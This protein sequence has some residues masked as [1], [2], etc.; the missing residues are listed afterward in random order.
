MVTQSLNGAWRLNIPGT[1]FRDV[2]ACVPGSVYHDLM[3]AGRIPDPFFRDNEMEAL[4][5]MENSFLYSRTFTVDP[6]LFACE[7]VGFAPSDCIAVEDSPNGCI[8]AI[9]AGC[10]TIMVPDLTEPDEALRARLFA[11]C[12]TLYDIRG[13]LD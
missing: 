1:E 5:L 9:D 6:S 3:E 7:R 12:D 11:V 8:S 10:K 2:P 13:Y 4:K